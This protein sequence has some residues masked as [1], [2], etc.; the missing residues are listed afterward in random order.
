MLRINII[1]Y[2]QAYTYMMGIENMLNINKSFLYHY[3][4]YRLY[5]TIYDHKNINI[6]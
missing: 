5:F 2:K 1:L 3:A 6:V 4:D